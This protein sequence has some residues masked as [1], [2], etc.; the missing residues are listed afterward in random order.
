LNTVIPFF[1]ACEKS[2]LFIIKE[3]FSD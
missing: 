3:L 1:F 2:N